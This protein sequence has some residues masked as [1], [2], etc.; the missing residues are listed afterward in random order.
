MF[1]VPV[2]RRERG[3]QVHDCRPGA[4][5]TGSERRDHWEHGDAQRKRKAATLGSFLER[6]KLNS[7]GARVD[8]L[9]LQTL[10]GN[11]HSYRAE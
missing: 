4:Q 5:G 7:I 3:R 11:P 8:F 6:C 1:Q 2:L 10:F 9:L